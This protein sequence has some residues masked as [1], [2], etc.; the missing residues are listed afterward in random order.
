MYRT[1]GGGGVCVCVCRRGGVG[2]F[3]SQA[4]WGSMMVVWIWVCVW[5]GGELVCGVPG[6]GTWGGANS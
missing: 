4:G 5:Y 3:E 6:G 2:G 1:E